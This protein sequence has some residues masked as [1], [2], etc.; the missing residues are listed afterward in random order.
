MGA[1]DALAAPL[2]EAGVVVKP[3][4]PTRGPLLVGKLSRSVIRKTLEDGVDVVHIHG[5]WQH[6]PHL[7]AREARRA[8]VPYVMRAA[9]ML[10][11]WALHK[12]RL[13]KRLHLALIGGRDLRGAGA[14]Q[15]TSYVAGHN[16][17]DLPMGTPVAVVS[18]RVAFEARGPSWPADLAGAKWPLPR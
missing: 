14:L 6:L 17:L 2:R 8:G 16:L 9:G 5:M 10:E 13:K 1:V 15:A 18:Q 11:P 4:G 7:A 12:G 3:T